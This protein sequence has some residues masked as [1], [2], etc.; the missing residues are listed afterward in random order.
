VNGNDVLLASLEAT[1]PPRTGQLREADPGQ[2]MRLA[3]LEPAVISARGDVLQFGG[4]CGEAAA[5]N[6]PVR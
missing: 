5:L 4:R 1:V 2:Q 3:A 6:G